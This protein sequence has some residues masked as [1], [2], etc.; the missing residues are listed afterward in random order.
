MDEEAEESEEQMLKRKPWGDTL[1][2]CPVALAEKGVLWPGTQ[3]IAA[4]LV[5][6][7]QLNSSINCIC[8][9]AL[10]MQQQEMLSWQ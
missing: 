7:C 8:S 1:H 10:Y 4:R 3:D 6:V 2:F 5:N 9:E